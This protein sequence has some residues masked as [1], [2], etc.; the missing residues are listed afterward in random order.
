[1][2]FCRR[3]IGYVETTMN[4]S[5][6][7]TLIGIL[8]AAI[9]NVAQLFGYEVAAGFSDEASQAVNEIITIIGLAFA[10]YGRLVAQAPGWL[11]K[12]GE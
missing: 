12:K 1:M 8:I 7:K 11:A 2:C 6:S 3:R 9:P 5:G 4:L 10:T